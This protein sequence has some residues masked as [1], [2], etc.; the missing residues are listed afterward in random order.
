MEFST[1]QCAQ[2]AKK[3]F[4]VAL[5]AGGLAGCAS[6]S[7]D[8]AA[9]SA[10]REPPTSPV[11]PPTNTAPVISGNPSTSAQVGM[12]YTFQPTATDAETPSGQLVFSISGCPVWATCTNGSGTNAGRITGMPQ[13][14]HVG[15]HT[16]IVVSVMDPQGNS[17]ALQTFSITVSVAANQAPTITGTPPTGVQVNSAYSFTPTVTDPDGPSRSFTFTNFPAWIT[18]RNTSTGLIGGTPVAGQEGT[19]SNLRIN[20]SDGTNSRTL[21]PFTITVTALPTTNQPPVISGS[22]PTSIVSG[23][24]Y[25]FTPIASDPNA[26]STLTFSIT[27]RPLWATFDPTTGT[28]SGLALLGTTSNIVI[29]V[30]DPQGATAALAPFS[31]NVQAAPP[32]GTATVTWTPPTTNTDDSQLTDLLG[33]RVYYGTNANS[34]TQTS[35]PIDNAAAVEYTVNSLASGTWYFAVKAYNAARVESDLSNVSSKVIP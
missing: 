17:S 3:F 20:V 14:A 12:T 30:R 5:L 24:L 19:Y 6:E 25:S 33:F 16:G 26:G 11:T 31:L 1:T 4:A 35:P 18:T 2:A 22:P 23:L 13:T 32:T 28:L 8:T 34:L 7:G 29:S 10:V 15:P 27:N 21:G 9:P